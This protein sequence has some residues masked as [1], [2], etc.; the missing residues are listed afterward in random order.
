MI[1][2]D[3]KMKMSSRCDRYVGDWNDD[4][5]KTDGTSNTGQRL[6]KFD[7]RR[8]Q[9]NILVLMCIVLQAVASPCVLVSCLNN[10]PLCLPYK[11]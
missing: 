9:V 8:T 4:T 11:Y 2:I 7:T 3:N 1:L 5:E 10:D 6:E